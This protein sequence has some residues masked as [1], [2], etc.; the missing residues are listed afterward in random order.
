MRKPKVL[1][2]DIETTGLRADWD[3]VLCA[4]Y[5]W[6][7][8]KRA[9]IIKAESHPR[10]SVLD[11]SG[12]VG[13]LISVLNEADIWVTHYGLKFDAPFIEARAALWKLP[14]LQQQP[15]DLKHVDTWRI[16][17]YKMKF[18]SNRL[19]NI[20]KF[21]GVEARK[22]LLEPRTWQQARIGDKKA[23]KYIYQHC[24]ADVDVLEEV[25]EIMLERGLLPRNVNLSNIAHDVV[26][27]RCGK[28][29]ESK[30]YRGYRYTTAGRY[31]KIQLIPCGH[32][33]QTKG[34]FADVL[35]R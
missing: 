23:L 5:K 19:D 12:A 25:F 29:V 3:T 18:W 13:E 11:D 4:A 14:A 21:F 22:T 31:R 6:R 16:A 17:R 2:W 24:L 15:T 27:P 30:Q 20:A 1:F 33:V 7:G 35:F 32:W 28:D 26:C 8:Q 10:K 34:N 9:K